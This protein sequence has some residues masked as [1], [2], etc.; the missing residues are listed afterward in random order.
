MKLT[1]SKLK[2]LIL[3]E[4]SE[5]SWGEI[6]PGPDVSSLEA[7]RKTLNFVNPEN[8]K[9]TADKY[10]KLFDYRKGWAPIAARERA[11]LY[12]LVAQEL[13]KRMS[14]EDIGRIS[15]DELTEAITVVLNE[16]AKDYIWGTTSASTIAN[17]Y[18]WRSL[19]G[20]CDE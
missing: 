15:K 3:E 6:P 11:E 4:L 8:I 14:G 17:Q 13:E 12:E 7:I 16:H 2:Q 9:N 1:I 10:E 5:T 18:G 19:K 20:S